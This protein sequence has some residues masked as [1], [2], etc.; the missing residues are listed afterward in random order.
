M[1]KLSLFLAFSFLFSIPFTFGAARMDTDTDP[2]KGSAQLEVYHKKFDKVL[3]SFKKGDVI[4]Y[5]KK[6]RLIERS[7]KIE[8]FNE[9]SVKINGKWIAVDK[10]R[11]IR[12]WEPWREV[13]AK[14]YLL[15]GSIFLTVLGLFQIQIAITATAIFIGPLLLGLAGLFIGAGLIYFVLKFNPVFTSGGKFK[16]RVGRS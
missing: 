14:N 5:R 3:H 9:N 12:K 8:D 16:F 10:I 13:L 15:L 6:N 4:T 1:K 7:G 2:E 11:N